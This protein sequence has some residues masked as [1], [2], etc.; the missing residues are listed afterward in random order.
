MWEYVINKDLKEI[1]TSIEVVKKGAFEQ[2][3][4]EEERA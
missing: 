4:M 2:I 3:G 1:G